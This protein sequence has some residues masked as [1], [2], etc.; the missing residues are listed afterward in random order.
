M[1]QTLDATVNGN[2]L[3]MA[4]VV[5]R[6]NQLITE[7]L[8]EGCLATLKRHG[9]E[10]NAITVAWTPG[11]FELPLV[12]KRFAQSGQVDAVIALGCVIRGATD[13]Y[14]YVCSGVTSGLQQAALQTNVPVLFGVLT[15]HT[16]EQALERA[17]TK[18]GNKG[19]DVAVAAIEMARLMAQLPANRAE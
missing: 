2:G 13:H 8:L 19:C 9:V 3:R 17:G 15:T 10:Q 1:V 7:N 11:A 12:A 5:S 14:D 18:A 6:F 16:I 4:V